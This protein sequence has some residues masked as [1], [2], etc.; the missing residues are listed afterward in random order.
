[1][2]WLG[3]KSIGILLCFLLVCLPVY[4]SYTITE[5]ELNELE[6][7]ILNLEDL[8]EGLQ[9]ENQLLRSTLIECGSTLQIALEDMTTLREMLNSERE[10]RRESEMKSLELFQLYERSVNAGRTQTWVTLIIGILAGSA[11]GY[12]VGRLAK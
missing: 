11:A 6:S 10:L 1:M 2:R 9:S 7:Y 4:S 3:S 5:E 12:L 8:S